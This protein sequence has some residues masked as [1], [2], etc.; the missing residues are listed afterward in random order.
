[1]FDEGRGGGGGDLSG[2]EQLQGPRKQC[3][4]YVEALEISA[5]AIKHLERLFRTQKER[6]NERETGIGAIPCG[7]RA[8]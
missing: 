5:M 8:L 2:N 7:P 6:G 1:M 3:L 4:V